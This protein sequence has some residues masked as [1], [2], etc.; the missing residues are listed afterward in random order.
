MI[1]EIY[2]LELILESKL[3]CLYD[4]YCNESLVN[5]IV[6]YNFYSIIYLI[7]SY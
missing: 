4:E 5:Y 2:L 7:E 1:V 6:L 3:L